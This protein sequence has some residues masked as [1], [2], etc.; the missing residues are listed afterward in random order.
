[1]N[2]NNQFSSPNDIKCRN[3]NIEDIS[4]TL[5]MGSVY[6]FGSC[7]ILLLRTMINSGS[8]SSKI[9]CIKKVL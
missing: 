7:N 2:Y 4:V 3:S 9:Y 1:M 5:N 6:G 8:Y